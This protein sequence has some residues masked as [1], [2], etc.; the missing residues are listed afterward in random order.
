[1]PGQVV[2]SNAILHAD[3]DDADGNVAKVLCLYPSSV[4]SAGDFSDYKFLRT[5]PNTL[6]VP[7][8]WT[9]YSGVK[10]FFND[11]EYHKLYARIDLPF[12]MALAWLNSGRT[13]VLPEEDFISSDV[14]EH[15]PIIAG[16][17]EDKL[18]LLIETGENS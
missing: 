17:I 1:M 18:S 9:W 4:I 5:K 11:A 12:A 7:T 15:S 16:C 10:A 8:R 3:N 13:V 14:R 2:K 6:L